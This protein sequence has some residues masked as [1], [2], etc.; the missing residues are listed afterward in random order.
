LK[1]CDGLATRWDQTSCTGGVFMENISS[2]YGIKS[3]WLKDGDLV[4]P[5][6]VVKERHKLY[7]YL[8]VTSRILQANGYDWK[9]AA[10]ICAHVEK[11]WVA[12]CF[13]SYGRDDSGFTHQNPPRIIALCRIA[14]RGEGDCVYGAS[15]DLTSNDANGTRAAQLCNLAP[16]NARSRCFS[17]I[18]TILGGF[19]SSPAEH[20]AACSSLTQTFLH[21]CLRGAGDIF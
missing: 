20:R 9:G 14:G 5:C 6:D 4:Y 19:S 13:Q 10:R 1:I 17:G 2:S 11:G 15:R 12:T 21:A 8:M 18:G 16:A 3:Q 7:C